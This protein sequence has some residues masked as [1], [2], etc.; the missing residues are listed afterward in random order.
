MGGGSRILNIVD[1]YNRRCLAVEVDISIRGERVVRVL[2]RLRELE[3][4]TEIIVM[5][6]VLT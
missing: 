4:L 3:G 6:N 5:D 1:D 2:E